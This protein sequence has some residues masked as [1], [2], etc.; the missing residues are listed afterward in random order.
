MET[1]PN[2]DVIRVPAAGQQQRAPRTE[3]AAQLSTVAAIID[4]VRPPGGRLRIL[5]IGGGETSLA[6]AEGPDEIVRLG[7]AGQNGAGRRFDESAFDCAISIDTVHRLDP[8]ERRA[9]LARLRRAATCMVM[10][11]SPRA[12][13]EHNPLEEA[14]ELFREFGDSVLVVGE[15]HLPALFALRELRVSERSDGRSNG[16]GPVAIAEHLLSPSP[17]RPRSVLISI[18]DPDAPGIDTSALKWCCSS[19]SVAGRDPAGLAVLPLS[20]EIRRLSDRLDGERARG[21]RAEAEAEELRRKVAELTRVVSED[22]L[23]RE[24]AEE[25]VEIVAAARGYRIGLAIC[26]FRAGVRRR[27]GSAWRALTAPW[28]AVAA[29]LS[30]ARPPSPDQ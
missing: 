15:E 21:R 13:N 11:E 5:E 29:R 18:I 17:S 10:V 24:S 26:R 4:L 19:P 1:G 22:R 16:S 8:A 7:D 20:L 2:T 30:Q 9:L 23:A 12:S 25:L 28:R 3:A 14:I 6:E 27:T